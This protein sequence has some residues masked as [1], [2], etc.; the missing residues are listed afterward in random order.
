MT[1]CIREESLAMFDMSEGDKGLDCYR[2]KLL[3]EEAAEA[4][5]LADLV[6]SMGDD[7]Q[8]LTEFADL[9]ASLED[10]QSEGAR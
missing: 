7:V 4:A 10:E 5:L 8:R 3:C 1:E 9:M 2:K 6:T